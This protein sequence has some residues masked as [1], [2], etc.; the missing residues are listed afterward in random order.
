[1]QT[2]REYT[3]LDR[4]IIGFDGFL[5]QLAPENKS[6][7]RPSPADHVVDGALTPEMQSVSSGLMRV[8]HAGE[9]AAQALYQ[10]QALTAR[11][12]DI[13]Q[14]MKT[15]A[16]EEVDHLVWCQQRLDELG[17]HTS[18]LG[19]VW[20]S[21]SLALG[22][23]AG[24]IG[25]RWSLGFLA[26][27]ENQVVRHL[28]SHLDKLPEPDHKSRAILEQMRKDESHHATVAIESGAVELPGVVRRL[29]QLCSKV[30]TTTA[31]RI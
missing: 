25:D 26:E 9:V 1:M 4:I 28:D 10:G 11:D 16:D 24:I 22:I 17:S 20:Y 8:N 15:S 19:P 5:H 3:A 13:Q 31:Y 30:M 23:L 18:Y 7:S 6:V 14:I 12:R 21:G 27:T 29:M 2:R